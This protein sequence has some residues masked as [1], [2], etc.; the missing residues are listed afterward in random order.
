MFQ[1]FCN[2]CT[3]VQSG[4]ECTPARSSS[5]LSV[6]R[7]PSVLQSTPVSHPWTPESGY[8]SP[9]GHLTD[10]SFGFSC[11]TSPFSGED[12][13]CCSFF[14]HSSCSRHM[15]RC[16]SPV[17]EQPRVDF[18][19]GLQSQTPVVRKV[20]SYLTPREL[21]VVCRTSSVWRR[22]CLSLPEEALR[23]RQYTKRRRDLW[24]SSRENLHSGKQEK[25]PPSLSLPLAESNAN[26][27]APGPAVQGDG[28]VGPRSR[29]DI[30]A[31]EAQTLK[32]GE[33]HLSCPLCSYPSRV[34]ANGTAAR[35]KSPTCSYQFCPKCRRDSHLPKP[36]TT[37]SVPTN[38]RT[39][40][41]LLIGSN[42]SKKQLRRL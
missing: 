32:E 28:A 37:I 18:L 12:A 15:P 39:R 25:K 19:R 4:M 6:H 22:L 5:S 27:E 16:L 29:H 40:K 9:G 33:W 13:S 3:P 26:V 23:W 34:A 1:S 38:P 2:P 7:T 31:Q 41:H 36:C 30:Y 14:P 24:E 42:Y 21:S 20:L 35:C 10:T 17:E 11:S 8:C